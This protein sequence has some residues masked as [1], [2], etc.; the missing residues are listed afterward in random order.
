MSDW[1][2]LSPDEIEFCHAMTRRVISGADRA[3]KSVAQSEI[4]IWESRKLLARV[5]RVLARTWE[6]VERSV[7]GAVSSRIGDCFEVR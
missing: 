1:Y 3:S 7:G 2:V 5:D 4:R 6:R